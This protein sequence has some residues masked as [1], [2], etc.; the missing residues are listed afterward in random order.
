VSLPFCP[1]C[2]FEYE[3]GIFTCPDCEVSLVAKLPEDSL[4]QSDYKDWIP[5]AQLTSSMDAEMLAEA[6]HSKGI[7]SVILSGSGYFGTTGQMGPSSFQP[8]G[9]GFIIAVPVDFARDADLEASG[10]LGE[11]WEKFKLVDIE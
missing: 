10:I 7:P 3:V 1:K 4:S 2:K 11:D 8:A 6:L 5:L 9:E